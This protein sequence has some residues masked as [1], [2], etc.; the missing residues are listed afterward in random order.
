MTTLPDLPVVAEIDRVRAALRER[1][2]CI[3]VA[4]P[5]AG[6]TTLIP[7]ALLDDLPDNSRLLLLEPRR[8]AARAA[9]RR[10]ADLLGER[11]GA[12]V[13]LTT[14]DDRIISRDTRIEVVTEGVLTR[15]LQNDPELPGVAAVI[16]DEV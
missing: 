1:G 15:R 5:G 4:P 3:L 9:A 2:R 7:I 11:V 14:R 13:G 8:L 16:F 10:M 6:K 12:T